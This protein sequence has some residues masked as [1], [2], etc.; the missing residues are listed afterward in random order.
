MRQLVRLALLLLSLV[1]SPVFC[2]QSSKGFVGDYD[3]AI[4]AFR[5]EQRLILTDTL[6]RAREGCPL[7]IFICQHLT[8]MA[9]EHHASQHHFKEAE[10]LLATVV[11]HTANPNDAVRSSILVRMARASL[12]RWRGNLPGSLAMWQALA[13]DAATTSFVAEDHCR[14]NG[15]L[16]YLLFLSGRL[17][18]AATYYQREVDLAATESLEA[19]RLHGMIGL[20]MVAKNQ[21]KYSSAIEQF[22]QV[23]DAIVNGPPD[24]HLV[25]LSFVYGN[26]A[27]IYKWLG[28]YETALKYY[29]LARAYKLRAG[30]A[31]STTV[32]LDLIASILRL[33]NRNAEAISILKNEYLPYTSNLASHYV[34]YRELALNQAALGDYEQA[35][36]NIGEAIEL[37]R[38]Q[39]NLTRIGD[40]FADQGAILTNLQRSSAAGESY[41]EGWV[42]SQMQNDLESRWKNLYGLFS[43][44]SKRGNTPVAILLGKLAV[45]DIQAMRGGIA[46]LAV[47]VQKS[48]LHDKK[49]VFF[50]L[51]ELLIQSGR[52]HE[53]REVLKM[54]KENE[55]RDFIIYD[56]AASSHFTSIAL[57][58]DEQGWVSGIKQRMVAPDT[59][60]ARD[61]LSTRAITATA[62]GAWSVAQKTT[63]P[64]SAAHVE[65]L[66]VGN[67]LYILLT[68]QGTTE[69]ITQD[70]DS[71]VMHDL[72]I[73]FRNAVDGYVI[74]A[75]TVDPRPT[76]ERLYRLL[77][78]PIMP[79]LRQ[80]GA[81]TLI[82]SLEGALR[83]LPF[84][85]L[86]DGKSYLVEHF[87]LVLNTS[88]APPREMQRLGAWKV[89]AMGSS[90][91]YEGF[92][93]LPG[94]RR[95]LAALVGPLG[96]PGDVY[97]DQK[98]TAD[99]MQQNLNS[100]Y[101]VMHIASHFQFTP[102][103]E[104]DSFLLLGDG[105]KLSLKELREGDFRFEGLDLLTLSACETA[106]HG[107]RD[108]NG[109]EVESFGT[110]AQHKGAGAV[111]ATLW[112]LSDASAPELMRD[113]YAG[114][115]NAKLTKVEALRRAQVALIRG[116]QAARDELAKRAPKSGGELADGK[117]VGPAYIYDPNAPFAHPYFW[118]PF[119]LMGDWR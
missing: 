113:F 95:E 39:K 92:D 49:N 38:K 70:I 103:T 86:Y 16:G 75:A 44:E 6:L 100:R 51:A 25:K 109:R 104:V 56:G 48:F 79:R 41:L 68:I 98:F 77:V 34:A 108:A 63:L 27:A 117:A 102:G 18:D 76:G 4:F 32:Y 90:E 57:S 40:Y 71:A 81:T 119:V 65:Y 20:G 5:N 12:L 115:E 89:A 83:Y 21:G 55:Y 13:Q 50:N 59:T 82:L 60:Q 58:P 3:R 28:Q 30:D 14:I 93:P 69:T 72:L 96:L 9:A 45:N 101:P 31:A 67:R 116:G 29:Q 8:V 94:V 26:L 84:G 7:E 114:R 106:M 85:A 66:L 87:G 15:E 64:E 62:H 11:E 54:F 111:L 97:L 52:L 46:D 2:E 88:A 61:W 19:R 42:F 23:V 73:A 1:S 112:R 17:A 78:A 10:S 99:Q 22:Q 107:G 43:I 24:H 118:A 105:R 47:A 74:N 33:Q 110:L 37:R 80:T 35:A 36:T 53:A 91:A